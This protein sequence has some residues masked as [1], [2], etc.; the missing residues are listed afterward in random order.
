MM[1]KF[2][3]FSVLILSCLYSGAQKLQRPRIVVGIVIDQMR[4]DYLY[5]FYDRYSPN[6]FKRIMREGFN[7][8]NTFIPYTPT[9]TAAGHAS[10]YT[11][12]VPALNGIMGNSWY[13]R[14][15]NRDV[16]CTEDAS[17]TTIGSTSSAGK[18]SPRNMWSTTVTDELRLATNFR[19]KTIA[20]AIKDRGSILPAGHSA[21]AAYWFDNASGGWISSS[22]YMKELPEWVKKFNAK[23]LPESYLKKTWNTLYPIKTY[24]QSTPDS[25]N[26]EI[27]VPGEDTYFPHRLDTVTR[28]RYDAFKYTPYGDSYT[29]DMARAAIEE[30]K[31][32]QLRDVTDF[33]A[34]SFSSTDYI[35]HNFGPNSIEIEDTYLRLD[36]E[37]A[38][39]LKYLDGRMG[40][41]NYLV[42]ITSDHAVAHNPYFMQ[43]S[44]L[45]AGSLEYN[46]V[47]RKM[48]DTLAKK[49]QVGGL[50]ARW[51]NYMLFLNDSIINKAGLDKKE[52]KTFLTGFLLRQPSVSNIVDLENL[53]AS[54]LPARLKT[55]LINGF[56]QKLSGDLQ[57]LLKPGHFQNFHGGATH[58]Q[59]HNY[60]AHIPLLWYGWKV[61]AGKTGREIYMTDIAPTIATM[62]NIQMPNASIGQPIWELTGE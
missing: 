12:S 4:W 33:L 32:G 22:Y 57:I 51:N 29:F 31:L 20:I 37:L 16:Y 30:E 42:F 18:M 23:Q 58:G 60:D 35:G 5:R 6:G 61:K 62:L 39:F 17:V 8:D 40:K 24:T 56:N 47:R 7:C 34:L 46:D 45:P 54:N 52:I 11:G 50:L 41:G 3:L 28:G 27:R 38:D 21:N 43:D 49:Y 53:A 15:L 1:R 19:N 10:I 13:D 59:W 48:N 25:N 26:Y 44:H 2:C 36:L 9:Q 14:T 55:M